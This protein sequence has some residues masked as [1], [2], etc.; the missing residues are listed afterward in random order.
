[1]IRVLNIKQLEQEG[2]L[3][4][5]KRLKQSRDITKSHAGTDI[6]NKFMKNT[7]DYQE[8]VDAPLKQN[9]KDGA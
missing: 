8:E 1:M 9:M 7:C 2:L 6:L 4:Y 3:E 5:I